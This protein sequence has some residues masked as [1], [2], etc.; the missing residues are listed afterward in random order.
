MYSVQYTD[1]PRALQSKGP[2]IFTNSS[3]QTLFGLES[4]SWVRSVVKWLVV[5]YM[6]SMPWILYKALNKTA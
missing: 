2:V 1:I 5:K 6:L 4:K 3:Q